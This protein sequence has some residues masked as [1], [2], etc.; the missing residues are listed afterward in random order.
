MNSL[1]EKFSV[2]VVLGMFVLTAYVFWAA[3][4]NELHFFVLKIYAMMTENWFLVFAGLGGV[5]L[6]YLNTFTVII[7][8]SA[9]YIGFLAWPDV[10]K[11]Q[12]LAR[13][14]DHLGEVTATSALLSD[15][16]F[17]VYAMLIVIAFLDVLNLALVRIREGRTQ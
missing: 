1:S 2:Y 10:E 9:G 16:G 6:Y 7:L 15:D 17:R 3:S 14:T 4:D 11:D 5:L 8:A 12:L 13:I